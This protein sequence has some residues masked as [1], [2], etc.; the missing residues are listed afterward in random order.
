MTSLSNFLRTVLR[1]IA[2]A[3]ML[4]LALL[5]LADVL[6]RYVFNLPVLGAVELTEALMVGVIFTGIVLATVQREHVTVD[7]LTIGRG[8]RGRCIQKV[9][10]QLIAAAISLL[11]G[12][13]TWSQAESALEYQDRTAMVGLPLGPVIVFMS[14]MLFF[15]AGVHVVQ[16]W[17]ELRME[18]HHD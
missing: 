8:R 11:L 4:A 2:E 14:L 12:A 9:V 5:T 3:G 1:R 7:L 15:N 13:V 18:R 17:R 16:L 6:G 10:G